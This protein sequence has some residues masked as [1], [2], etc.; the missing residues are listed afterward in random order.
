[1]DEHLN[2]AVQAEPEA[3]QREDFFMDGF[4]DEG[5]AEAETAGQQEE[6]EARQ[7]EADTEQAAADGQEQAEEQ[8]TEETP[9]QAPEEPSW[10][11]RHMDEEK[12]MKAADI[13][14]EL[15]QRGLDYDRVRRKYEEAKPVIEMMRGFARNAN[16]ELTDY[17]RHIRTEAKKAE[18]LTDAEAKR[19]LEL[20]DR[21][22]AVTAKEAEAKATADAKEAQKARIQADLADFAKAFPEEHEKAKR[23]PNAIPP[24]VWN[25]VNSGKYSLT[26]AFARYMVSKANTAAA[27][28]E[29]NAAAATLNQKNAARST[30]SMQTSGNEK[31]IKD[32]FE[33]GFG[34]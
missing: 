11:I 9:A 23:D 5:A 34:I 13:T 26:A 15:L 19:H 6:A 24:E 2:Q 18:G 29:K 20:E 33:E 17:I 31:R 12:V 7:D 25:E 8:P 32:P 21:E 16:M 1:M 27:A 10:K 14:P 22:A 4:G 30:G 3:D 28:A